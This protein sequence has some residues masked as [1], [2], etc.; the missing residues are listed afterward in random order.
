MTGV[1]TCALPIYKHPQTGAPGGVAVDL[2]RELAR[3]IGAEAEIIGYPSPGELAEAAPTDI[4]DVGF[5]GDEPARAKLIDFSPAYVE[6]EATYLLPPGSAI[7][8]VEEV[9][10]QQGVVPHNL[11]GKN[12]SGQLQ[13]Q[14]ATLQTLELRF[15]RKG[16]R[17]SK[18]AL[19]DN[20]LYVAVQTTDNLTLIVDTVGEDTLEIAA[21]AVAGGG[22]VRVRDRGAQAR[23]GFDRDSHAER[24]QAFDSVGRC[25]DAPLRRA[26]FPQHRE[27]HP[28]SS[29]PS[30]RA[31]D[32]A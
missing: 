30:P 31:G 9:D 7:K 23:S 21:G 27:A 12:P 1:Q 14:A 16:K 22:E 26:P 8:S 5:L 17:L 20:N 2:G 6:I 11:P 3:R 19:K 25:R 4:W 24:G 28:S 10:R 15:K 13:D 32:K 18:T 29:L